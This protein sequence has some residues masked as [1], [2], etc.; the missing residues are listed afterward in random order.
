[1]KLTT[2]G[3]H[4][5]LCGCQPDEGYG[6]KACPKHLL[7]LK[8]YDAACLVRIKPEDETAREFLFAVLDQIDALERHERADG[9]ERV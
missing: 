7:A 4:H 6:L 2:V 1:M 9:Y 3:F 8:L 5:L